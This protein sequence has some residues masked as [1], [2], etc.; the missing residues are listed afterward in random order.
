MSFFFFFRY[1]CPE[2]YILIQEAHEEI[3]R[4]E[5]EMEMIQESASLFEVNIPE[6]KQL[7]QCRREMKM[8]KVSFHDKVLLILIFK[9]NV[10]CYFFLSP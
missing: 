7:K 4:Y 10:Q 5:D 3:V 6:F 2:S 1:D 8:L 9:C